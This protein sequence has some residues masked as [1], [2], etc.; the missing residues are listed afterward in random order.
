MKVK[1][2][3][4]FMIVLT[5][6]SVSLIY[7]FQKVGDSEMPVAYEGYFDIRDHDFRVE[8]PV[9]LVGD[10][11]F[12]PGQLVDSSYF[13]NNR[14]VHYVSVPSMWTNYRIEDNNVPA[15][16]TATYRLLVKVPK[17][18]TILG[19]KTGN[20]RM[21]NA[22]YINGEKIG[23]SGE[24]SGDRN[25]LPRNTPYISFFSNEQDELEILVHVAN[26]HY[27]SGGG[28]IGSLHLGDVQGIVKLRQ[29]ALA[30]DWIMIAAFFAAAI[31]FLGV[32]LHFQR[33][34]GLL[35]F[36]MFCF[37]VVLYTATHGE[38]VLHD[39][40]PELSYEFFATMQASSNL[41]SIFILAYFHTILRNYSSLKVVRFLIVIGLILT[42]TSLLPVYIQSEFQV[43]YSAYFLTVLLYVLKIQITAIIEKVTG[44]L[45]L[46]FGS[47]A[48][49]IY[50]VTSTINVM[51]DVKINILPPI[52]PYIYLLMLALFMAKRFTDTYRKNEE[53]SK[54]LM[55][56]DQTKDEFLV[57][58]SHEFK[59]P[60][61]G[62]VAILQTILTSSQSSKDTLTTYQE[63]NIKFVINKA[64]GLSSLVN[65]IL[66][67]DKLKR[68]E[69][70][71]HIEDVD[72]YSNIYVVSEVFTYM[73]Q[74]DISIKN[75][76]PK[77][78]PL[79]R[80][81]ENRLSQILYNLMDN[82][83]K[84]T[85]L[86]YIEIS[87]KHEEDKVIVSI[88]DTGRGIE[89]SDLER[90][91]RDYEHG[92]RS[93]LGHDGVGLGL[94]IVKHLIEIQNGEI[95]VRSEVGEG[96]VF[97][98]SLPISDY[99][100]K[101][102]V[103]QNLI[104]K[105]K[106]PLH[107][108]LPLPL[109]VG[110]HE[111][112]KVI[113]ADDNHSNLRILIE[114]LK[115][116]DYHIIAVDN[117]AD[118][119]QLVQE[120]YDIDLLLLDMMMPGLSGY[121]VCQQIREKYSVTELPVIMLTA[122]VIP[123]DMVAAF[124]SG[125][126]DF[127]PK[128]FNLTELKVR[129][130][131]VMLMK[132]ASQ[133]ATNME[134]A[135]LQAQIKPHFIYNVLNSIMS[136]S[137]VNVEKARELIANFATFLRGSFVFMNTNQLIPLRNEL[138]LV[139]SYV[140]IEKARYPDQFQFILENRIDQA[141]LLPPFLIQPLVE[142]AIRHGVAARRKDGL[143]VL[144]II[145]E[146]QKYVNITITDNGNGMSLEKLQQVQMQDLNHES[147][148][149]LSN[150]IKRTKQF[151]GSYSIDSEVGKGTTISL[152]IPCNDIK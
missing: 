76:V 137:Y 12:V 56:I 65:D 71:I 97:S 143:V 75:T 151:G 17:D 94:S 140:E 92:E 115:T 72:L 91:F 80:V 145:L 31:Y 19:I 81:D 118:V 112:K 73:L 64:K 25:Y 49:L 87:A 67:L 16:T 123:E 22:I 126:N 8:G 133:T 14:A 100:V 29:N 30:Y 149:G 15:Y 111:G 57:K 6:T 109:T 86:G 20:I 60:L 45:Y 84:Y 59:A 90:I 96:T 127:L 68:K 38:K 28:I 4:I 13:Q 5:I 107:F 50:F 24:P 119:L 37:S 134:V 43:V 105:D 85:D 102:Q 9:R 35:F 98:F 70:K 48:L 46:L 74:K 110:S 41:I 51:G 142:N 47:I 78:L 128:P 2:L 114:A 131:N 26:F 138:N 144:K 83:I 139:Q 122:A 18:E 53:L 36:S 117:G 103:P 99:E 42:A 40:Y 113:V 27:A 89:A 23:Q 88:K 106:S 95:W 62:I 116:E 93:V 32:Y 21:S 108:T 132:H 130:K 141:S 3:L 54:K 39:V 55:Q 104:N 61:S 7:I 101:K 1:S 82:A 11:A 77:D 129:M 147:G 52:L 152:L 148:V 44:G 135:F 136:L 79:V 63:E 125:A 124:R 150:T 146:Q 34:K 121:E 120:H 33:D 58:T 10:W 66:D 69:L